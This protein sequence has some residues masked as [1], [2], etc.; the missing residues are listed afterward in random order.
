MSLTHFYPVQNAV[1]ILNVKMPFMSLYMSPFKLL[2]LND[3]GTCFASFK[4]YWGI[5]NTVPTIRFW[6]S[7]FCLLWGNSCFLGSVLICS[8]NSLFHF[9]Y[10]R[11]VTTTGRR[12]ATCNSQLLSKE[13]L[14]LLSSGSA[15]SLHSS[16]RSL[17]WLSPIFK[18]RTK[19]GSSH[20]RSFCVSNSYVL[21]VVLELT[22][23]PTSPHPPPALGY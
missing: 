6:G 7:S 5:C 12:K 22:F 19:G 11:R 3:I 20:G 15:L 8:L 9:S 4:I 21:S 14:A 2:F 23:H 10:L 1:F 13:N 16:G 18:G 17:I